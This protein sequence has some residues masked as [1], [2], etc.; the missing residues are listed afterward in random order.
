MRQRNRSEAKSFRLNILP[1]SDCAP[2]IFRAFRANLMI[3]IDRG[4]GGVS[5]VKALNQSVPLCFSVSLRGKGF[6]L[7]ARRINRTLAR[8]ANFRQP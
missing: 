3:P 5:K 6:T 7:A 2:R 4:E 1:A 8:P